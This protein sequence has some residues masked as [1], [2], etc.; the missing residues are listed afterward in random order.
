MHSWSTARQASLEGELV[1]AEQAGL[2]FVVIPPEIRGAAFFRKQSSLSIWLRADKQSSRAES[3]L[4]VCGRPVWAMAGVCIVCEAGNN[5]TVDRSGQTF[6][7]CRCPPA[8][9]GFDCN[10]FLRFARDARM[11]WE[12]HSLCMI[13]VPVKLEKPPCL[14]GVQFGTCGLVRLTDDVRACVPT[15]H[16]CVYRCPICGVLGSCLNFSSRS[17]PSR[18]LVTSWTSR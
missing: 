1:G 10:R 5:Q 11:Q 2:A 14:R 9:R 12:L 4:L 13:G 18:C 3:V 8:E 7:I 15:Y 16:P 6:V 17:I